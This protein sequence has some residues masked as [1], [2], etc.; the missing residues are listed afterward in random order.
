LAKATQRK[1]LA[2]ATATSR[3]SAIAVSAET[4]RV[5]GKSAP[6]SATVNAT[7]GRISD[8]TPCALSFFA[9]RRHISSA[10]TVSV[11]TGRCGPWASI[12]PTGT[13]AT[14]RSLIASSISVQL[15][16]LS[17]MLSAM[18]LRRGTPSLLSVGAGVAQGRRP[19]V[20]YVAFESRSA[21]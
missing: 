7:G 17:T 16:S 18:S 14:G 20:G 21:I 3:S 2:V 15:I 19:S 4:L 8:G 12:A 13:S 6:N 9:P 1:R 5:P 11:D 10:I